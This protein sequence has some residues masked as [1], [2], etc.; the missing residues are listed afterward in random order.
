MSKGTELHGLCIVMIKTLGVIISYNRMILPA[1][2]MSRSRG[3]QVSQVVEVVRCQ[4][5]EFIF[6]L[7]RFSSC[8]VPEVVKLL[9]SEGNVEP[10]DSGAVKWRRSSWCQSSGIYQS[11]GYVDRCDYTVTEY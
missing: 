4:V 1:C 10:P 7:S 3:C 5:V 11:H 2:Q 9:N 6:K 8:H